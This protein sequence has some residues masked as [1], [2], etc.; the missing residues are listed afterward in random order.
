MLKK[1]DHSSSC[2]TGEEL[3]CGNAELDFFVYLVGH[4]RA[5]HSCPAGAETSLQGHPFHIFRN[6][7][8]LQNIHVMGWKWENKP[9]KKNVMCLH[10]E[11][12]ELMKEL[13]PIQMVA[14]CF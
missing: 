4:V 13:K 8:Q 10:A 12:K 1:L 3:R 5:L 14:T 7:Q 11:M 6:L 2:L 9:K